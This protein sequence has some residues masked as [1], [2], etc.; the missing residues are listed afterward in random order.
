MGIQNT[1]LSGLVEQV[2]K[3]GQRL[4]EYEVQ[5]MLPLIKAGSIGVPGTKEVVRF[6]WSVNARITV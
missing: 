5:I 6:A 2:A 4:V 1:T 3:P